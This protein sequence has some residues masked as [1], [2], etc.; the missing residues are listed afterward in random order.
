MTL[1]SKP[2]P[3]P[4]WKLYIAQLQGLW[5]G[6]KVPIS[7]IN[8]KP[9]ADISE[10]SDDELELLVAVAQRQLDAFSAQLEQIR[11]RAQFLF[12]TLIILI[13]LAA[14]ALPKI[15]DEISIGAFIAWALSLLVLI[16]ALF[17]TAGIV[18]NSKVMG[19]VDS[20]WITRQDRPWLLASAQDHLESV[21]PSWRTVAT[22][23]T[24]LRDSALLTIVGALGV[25]GAWCWA[26][27]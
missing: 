18:V 13:G 8:R 9:P 7:D 4:E 1:S 3:M 24:L 11:Q 15:I 19:T 23:V 26:L 12:S 2:D 16:V 17:G 20:A 22:H 10:C 27:L 6:R 5:A 21:E 14:A 25:G